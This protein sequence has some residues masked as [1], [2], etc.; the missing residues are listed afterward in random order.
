MKKELLFEVIGGIDDGYITE[1]NIRKKS[2]NIA[3]YAAIAASILLVAAI[4]VV[5]GAVENKLPPDIDKDKFFDDHLE[6]VELVTYNDAYY[7]IIGGEDVKTLKKFNLPSRITEDMVGEKLGEAAGGKC[8]GDIYRYLPYGE[9]CNAVCLFSEDGESYKF[10][11]FCNFI[12]RDDS[13]YETADEMFAIYGVS[14]AEDVASIAFDGKTITD[15]EEIAEIFNAICSSEAMGNAQF[16]QNVFGGRSED[17]QQR[18]STELAE[19]CAEVRMETTAG[20]VIEN[21]LYYRTGQYLHW[22]LNYYKTAV[23][24]G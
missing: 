23:Q 1:E 21:L 12:H 15:R 4:V 6:S 5:W 13:I 20:V 18:L 16:Q 14:A 9:S 3:K 24:I 11:L 8:E 7:Q 17:E 10:A 2:G 19:N 22:S